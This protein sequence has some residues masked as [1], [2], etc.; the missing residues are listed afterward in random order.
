MYFFTLTFTLFSSFLKKIFIILP[1][2]VRVGG[3]SKSIT[4]KPF[5]LKSLRPM[6]A[7]TVA[8]AR[9]TTRK[10]IRMQKQSFQRSSLLMKALKSS[11]IS[12]DFLRDQE[13]IQRR[14]YREFCTLAGRRSINDQLLKWLDIARNGRSNAND[15]NR[16]DILME[17]SVPGYDF[18]SDEED[19]DGHKMTTLQKITV[20]SIKDSDNP[21]YMKRNFK[22]KAMNE[23]EE[24]RVGSLIKLN[25]RDRWRLYR[26]W[27]QRL[28]KKQQENLQ[29]CQ[30]EFEEALSRDK[31]LDTMTEYDV[32]RRARVI[33]MTTTCAARYRHIL[34]RIS[35]KIVLVEEA[36]E[37]LEAH[38][39]TSLSKGCQ[40]L[41]LIGD[42]QQLRP[43][44]TVYEL[45]KKYNLDVSLFERMVNVG[46]SC[47][48]LSVQHRMRPEIA[49]LLK[50]IYPDLESHESVKEYKDIKGVKKNMFFVNHSHLENSNDESH[51]HTNEHEAAF[52][53]ALCRYLLQQ[54]YSAGQITLMTTYTGQ[55]FAIRDCIKQQNNE[56]LKGVRLTT[57]DNFQGEENDIILLS[58]V[59]S[60][61]NEKVGFIKIVNRACVA[62]SRAKKGFYCIGN[63]DLLS[64]HNEM[65][66]KIVADLKACDSIGNA[67]PLVCETHKDEVAAETAKD[68]S[69]KVPDGGCQRKCEVRLRCGHACKLLC[70]P[71]DPKHTKYVCGE[72]CG[73]NIEGCTHTCPNR[74][75]EPCEMQCKVIVEKALPICGHITQ[76][77]CFT[78]LNRIPCKE[79]CSNVLSCNHRC[80]NYCQRPCTTECMELVKRTDWP[81]GHEVTVACSATPYDCPVPCRANLDCGH[82]CP[83]TCGE[84]RM[85]RIHQRCKSRCGRVLVCSH[86]CRKTCAVPCPPCLQTCE[87]RCVHSK[88]TNTCGHLCVPCRE[89]CSWECLHHKCFK[90]CHEM[91]DRPRCN[92]PCQKILPCYHV[93][94]GLQCQKECICTVCDKNDGVDPITTIFL[95]GEEDEDARFMKLPDCGHIFA[96]S[97][98]DRYVIPYIEV[99]FTLVAVVIAVQLRI[100][101][102]SKFALL[103]LLCC[104]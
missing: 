24:L 2:I 14:H 21:N 59:R 84:C 33:G 85:G 52:V 35:P 23:H 48:K 22:N 46:I 34:Q 65:W 16:D 37:V 89:P 79:R 102:S 98:L 70:H 92:R 97:D 58:L 20:L 9:R 91:C 66:S 69:E 74:C 100:I 67:L 51:S 4:L 57:V 83:G 45:A 60:N 68:F 99:N 11:I 25:R 77:E 50:H 62:L 55:M 39:I 12:L 13:C 95:G 44:P 43:N 36:A 30:V 18:D 26:L 49:A 41:I 104:S 63:F 10:D 31:E 5:N 81:C 64:K 88:C 80:Q 42:H 32:L 61:K 76:V 94:R 101:L 15:D 3:R 7:S 29:S 75:S 8:H 38:L 56:E 96:V 78:D 86:V 40:H 27:C 73:R 53:V 6:G 54:G 19:I 1:G 90:R 93:C 82:T 87:N 47:E 17:V 28:E 71:G 103:E 72:P